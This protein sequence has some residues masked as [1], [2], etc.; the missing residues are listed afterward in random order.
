MGIADDLLVYGVGDTKEDSERDHHKCLL[1][2]LDRV[3]A[4]NLKLNPEMIQFKLKK[5]AF[6]GSLTI[7]IYLI[8]FNKKK[9]TNKPV[10]RDYVGDPYIVMKDL[11][12]VV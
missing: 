1:A 11:I 9:Q 8:S 10:N 5:I 6:M 4:R 2:L 12:D 3:R 7:S